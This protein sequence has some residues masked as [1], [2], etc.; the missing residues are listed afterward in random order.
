MYASI[1][2]SFVSVNFPFDIGS[3]AVDRSRQAGL[4]IAGQIVLE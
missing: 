3:P 4:Q 2:W 1:T